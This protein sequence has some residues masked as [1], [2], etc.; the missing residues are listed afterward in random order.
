MSNKNYFT[1]L[2]YEKMI[3][4]Y[5]IGDDYSNLIKSISRDELNAIQENRF[6]NLIRKAWKIPFY[7]KHWSNSGMELGDI[8]SLEHSELIPSY[9]KSDLMKSIEEYPPFGNFHG[10][11]FSSNKN[12]SPVIFHTTSGTTG[13]PQNLFFGP[14]S[15]E[16]QNVML[17]RAYHIQG[18]G[19]K[20]VVHSVYGHGMIN[21]GH[22]V[23]ETFTHYLPALYLSAGTGNETR[24]VQQ[25][26][27]MARFGATVIVGFADYIVKLAQ[28]AIDEGLKPGIDIPIRMIIGHMGRES[29]ESISKIWGGAEIYDL[30]GVGD[31]GIVAFEAQDRE[32]MYIHEDAYLVELMNPET[33]KIVS[34]GEEGNMII[35]VLFK[36]DVYPVIRFDTKDVSSFDLRPSSIDYKFKRITGFLGRSD[37]MIK[38]RGINLYP[39]A[40]GAIANE[41][42]ASTGEYICIA[43]RDSSGR[44]ELTVFVEVKE[45]NNLKTEDEIAK[46][47]KSRLGIGINVK[48]V[49]KGKTA[50]FTQVETRQ[51]AIRLIDKRYSKKN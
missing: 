18:I 9:S 34:D 11:D 10:V 50:K 4:D 8:V 37:N 2:N 14:W 48:I 43:D 35:T 20:D 42:S 13:T 25:V 45:I 7:K 29:R 12:R 36:D 5:P 33:G 28:V 47:L 21:G 27:N 22:Y 49:E 16:L 6:L 51:K 31:T 26:Q 19:P 30:Y 17:A 24:S 15:R 41:H 46:E 44:E 32:G 3:K 40:I 38:L 39:I 1:S 23:R